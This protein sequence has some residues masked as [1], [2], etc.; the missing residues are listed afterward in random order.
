M[1]VPAYLPKPAEIFIYNWQQ[2]LQTKGPLHPSPS[3][4]Q[5]QMVG[6]D[7]LRA[8]CTECGHRGEVPFHKIHRP[9]S[10]PIADLLPA[11]I[12]TRCGQKGPPTA[13]IRGVATHA[14]PLH[15]LVI[16]PPPDESV[17]PLTEVTV[18]PPN[19]EK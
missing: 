7:T 12:C 6:Y 5:V 9:S 11:L 19:P 1:R 16:I 8:E 13:T 15:D 18:D 4:A 2:R 3:I 17:A 14:D 10:T